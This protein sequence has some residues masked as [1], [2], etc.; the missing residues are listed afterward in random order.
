ML[1]QG[2]KCAPVVR[3]LEPDVPPGLESSARQVGLD[4]SVLRELLRQQSELIS[5]AGEENRMKLQRKWEECLDRVEAKSAAQD[6]V[7]PD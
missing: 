3:L 2:S 4:V 1:A 7:V 6:E 5:A